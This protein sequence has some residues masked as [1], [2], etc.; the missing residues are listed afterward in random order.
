MPHHHVWPLRF[1]HLRDIFLR[2]SCA[3]LYMTGSFKLI[4]SFWNARILD[5]Y[6]P[7]VWMPN[8]WVYALV[9]CLEL[10]IACV[11]VRPFAPVRKLLCILWLSTLFVIYRLLRI[12][13]GVQEPCS[14]LGNVADWIP[15]V[16]PFIGPALTGV[17]A[18]L[19]GGSVLF[20]ALH[21]AA[22]RRRRNVEMRDAS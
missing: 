8:R 18:F 9:G 13:A 2:L 22:T 10:G 19:F 15:S 7:L 21:C 6:D 11:L 16:K 20:L 12:A 17:L 4:S 3:I 14:C 5:V 1:E